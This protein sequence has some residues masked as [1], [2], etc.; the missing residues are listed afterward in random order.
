V[1]EIDFSELAKSACM[2]GYK[3]LKSLF[4][5]CAFTDFVE[6]FLFEVDSC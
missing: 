1:L 2:Q 6:G 4:L 3:V 5:L